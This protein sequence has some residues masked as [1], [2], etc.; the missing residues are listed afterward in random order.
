ME[1]REPR[2]HKTHQTHHH[3]IQWVKEA[4]PPIFP[5]K[6]KAWIKAWNCPHTLRVLPYLWK[7]VA[8]MDRL[9]QVPLTP[10][11]EPRFP[12]VL[13]LHL[14]S[15]LQ[16]PGTL[17]Q[18][19][20][21]DTHFGL[22]SRLQLLQFLSSSLDGCCCPQQFCF[23]NDSWVFWIHP[24]CSCNQRESFLGLLRV[25]SN[26]W[27]KDSLKRVSLKLQQKWEDVSGAYVSDFVILN[28]HIV[29]LPRTGTD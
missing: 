17:A 26:L 29:T 22:C 5:I 16:E 21:K 24:L 14:P 9:P 8:H 27:L 23:C 12:E 28:Q 25:L 11:R 15:T 19:L 10:G 1:N 3:H 6:P 20:H 7:A 4:W 13:W 2:N 18:Q